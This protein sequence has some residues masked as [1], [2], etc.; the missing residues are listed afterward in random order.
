[1]DTDNQTQSTSKEPNL[2]NQLDTLRQQVAELQRAQ[3]IENAA[4]NQN[5]AMA[6][7]LA[8]PMPPNSLINVISS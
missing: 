2:E 4:N 7:P 8:N 6:L 3:Q 5:A 1:M